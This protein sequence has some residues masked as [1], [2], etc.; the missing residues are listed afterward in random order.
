MIAVFRGHL[1]IDFDEV[2]IHGQ[3][4]VQEQKP[5]QIAA[6]RRQTCKQE[7]ETRSAGLFR[8]NS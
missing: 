6:C 4:P 3:I 1:G 7:A 2:E 5:P 8:P